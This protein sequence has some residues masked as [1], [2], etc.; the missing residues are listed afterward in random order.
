MVIKVY[1]FKFYFF[2]NFKFEE[3]CEKIEN[4]GDSETIKWF[5]ACSECSFSH[6]YPLSNHSSVLFNQC[7]ISNDFYCEIL[8]ITSGNCKL[9]LPDYF[10][11]EFGECDNFSIKGCKN[12]FKNSQYD[13]KFPTQEI[14]DPMIFFPNRAKQLGCISCEDNFTKVYSSFWN[15]DICAKSKR[16]SS[17]LNSVS[18]E[19]HN[20][21]KFQVKSS[22]L[23]C[24]KCNFGFT[25]LSPEGTCFS[26]SFIPNCE[27]AF[28]KQ[29]CKT[30]SSG[31][32]LNKSGTCS[33]NLV[34]NC[35]EYL[36]DINTSKCLKCNNGYYNF[37]GICLQGSI[38]NCEIYDF[39]NQCAECKNGFLLL[40]NE[41]K[42]ICV[43]D[44]V[45]SKCKQHFVTQHK[46]YVHC[47][48]CETGYIDAYYPNL[49]PFYHYWKFNDIENCK[50][51]LDSSHELIQMFKNRLKNQITV[52]HLEK[53]FS[54]LILKEKLSPSVG[55]HSSLCI[56]CED[57]Y[58]LN[59][60]NNS[61]IKTTKN[62]SNCKIYGKLSNFCF[63][64]EESFLLTEDNLMC[65]PFLKTIQNCHQYDSS[66]HCQIC[67]NKHYPKDEKCILMPENFQTK[68]CSLYNEN[69]TCMK[70]SSGFL[71]V[72]NQCIALQ[73]SNCKT[74]ENHKKCLT[75]EDNHILHLLPS[76]LVT[77]E[78]QTIPH[79]SQSTVPL[80]SNLSPLSEQNKFSS[81]CLQCET[82]FF[83]SNGVCLAVSL[84]IPN[85]EVNSSSSSCK[86]CLPG[87]LLSSSGKKCFPRD[88]RK[89]LSVMNQNEFF[90]GPNC[91][92]M[93][94]LE[95]AICLL[96]KTGYILYQGV[97]RPCGGEGCL[98]CH[99]NDARKC[100]ICAAS[101]VMVAEGECL[102]V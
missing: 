91:V 82:N 6:S 94:H 89:G 101:Y 35:S 37:K 85:C 43:E 14:D 38:S 79:C 4:C 96:C 22:F 46:S 3:S 32:F 23:I 44:A 31:Y 77:C 67:A 48:E 52:Q 29:R 93:S 13:F 56:E 97:C 87:F 100:A 74:F 20:C 50:K 39:E 98:Q 5:N 86:T 75:C 12:G 65:V 57:N 10:P 49:N 40:I 28:T 26:Q 8:D 42:T 66:T 55:V 45:D 19:E 47:N 15:K 72:N 21:K 53:E 102:K 16:L 81:W 71:L 92:E 61:C 41:E 36:Q 34:E 64:C 73:V 88:Y 69:M 95:S 27:I 60:E 62:I 24:S 7:S 54:E 76:G 78:P 63:L 59:L 11:N 33:I 1:F 90:V 25:L 9:C 51:Y 99:P 80:P 68:N 18:F 83:P 58:Y 30:C 84:R 17:K 70:C 2:G